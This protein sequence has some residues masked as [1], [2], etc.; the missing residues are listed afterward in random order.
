MRRIIIFIS[1]L[2]LLSVTMLNAQVSILVSG[3]EGCDSLEIL[4]FLNP[5]EA[6]D[7]ISSLSWNIPETGQTFVGDTVLIEFSVPGRYTLNAMINGRAQ[8]SFSGDINV[9]DSPQS[10]FTYSFSSANSVFSYFF[11]ADNIVNSPGIRYEWYI[12]NNLEGTS[13]ELVY[14]FDQEGSYPV[15]LKVI[16]EYNC[17]SMSFQEIIVSGNL[18]CPNVFTPNMDGYNDVFR[19]NTDGTTV[20]S[21][22][23]YSRTGIKVYQSESPSI[24]WDGR[25]LS[26]VEMQPGIYFY[27][28]EPVKGA[29]MEKINGFVHL[30]R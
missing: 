12:N 16:N 7:T 11:E 18:Q 30:I 23:V 21:F 13:P 24:F 8:V 20:Y 29:E 9:Y 27:L 2:H 14:T 15:Q 25:S 26:G 22:Q 3:D 19:V 17:E 28:I 10:D 5:P 4:A 1:A 6:Y